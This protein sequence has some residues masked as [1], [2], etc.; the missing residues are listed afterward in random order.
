LRLTS[1]SDAHLRILGSAIEETADDMAA[2]LR[3]ADEAYAVVRGRE[4]HHDT[5]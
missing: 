2:A 4:R 5:R 1:D 3:V